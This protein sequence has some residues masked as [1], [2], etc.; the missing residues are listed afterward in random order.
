MR[1][2][3][4]L[5]SFLS[6]LFANDLNK[7]YFTQM[8]GASVYVISLQESKLDTTKLVSNNNEEK[9]FISTFSNLKPNQLNIIFIKTKNFNI[10]IDTGFPHNQAKLKLEL[11]N[12]GIDFSDITH[13]ILTHAHP[14]H[15]GGILDK[16]GQNNFV[17]AQLFIDENELNFWLNSTNENT[18]KALNAFSKVHFFKERFPMLDDDIKLFAIKAYGH[19]PGHNLISIK[20]ESGE[21]LVFMG[22]LVHFYDIQSKSPNINV[23]YDNNK[24]QAAKNRAYFLDYFKKNKIPVVGAHMPISKPLFLDEN[25]SQ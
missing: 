14:D 11:N 24:T 17:N 7:N 6:V 1:I 4:S 2:L 10:L 13:L 22:D 18:K 15:V 20:S 8:Q 3:L 9:N 23:V 21:E 25:L 16:E 5:L 19:T 12:I